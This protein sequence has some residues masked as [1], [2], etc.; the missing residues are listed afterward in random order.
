MY[1]VWIL[2]PGI[3]LKKPPPNKFLYLIGGGVSYMENIPQNFP[4]AARSETSFLSI[5]T[6]FSTSSAPQAENFALLHF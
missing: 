3:S 4:P 2:N 1:A 5:Y 6:V